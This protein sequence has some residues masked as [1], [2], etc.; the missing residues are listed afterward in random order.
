[1]VDASATPEDLLE[2]DPI[3][4]KLRELGVTPQQLAE[5]RLS[6]RRHNF[7]FDLWSFDCP[8]D[9]PP[10]ARRY[11]RPYA[12][13]KYLYLEDPP[14]C[15]DRDAA[16][17]LVAETHA[18]PLISLGRQTKERQSL[19]AKKL[20]NKISP[21]G[22]TIREI[23]EKLAKINSAA[24]PITLWKLFE[25]KLDELGLIPRHIVKRGDQSKDIIEYEGATGRRKIGLE[26]FRNIISE[27]RRRDLS[28]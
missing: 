27:I 10:E 15:A 3:T 6:H 21:D 25:N 20:R 1:M 17:R 14:P 22:P 23:I 4:R 7:T 12:A 18:D 19:R 2:S 28:R 13:L 16:W 5:V 11:L 9:L 24:D 8:L 26:R